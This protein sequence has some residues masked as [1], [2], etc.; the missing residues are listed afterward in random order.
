M[1]SIQYAALTEETLSSRIGAI[2][3]IAQRLGGDPSGWS[4]EEVGDGNLNLVFIVRG[5]LDTVIVKQ[6][7]PY[8]RMVGDS[9]P[10]PLYRATYEHHALVRQAERDPGSV[11]EVIH[12]D[13]NQALIAMEYLTPHTIL[14]K[15]LIEG[16]RV[17]G[18]GEFLGKFC[19]RTAFRGSEL[20]MQSADKKA[21][22]GVFSGNVA[23]PAI[24]EALVFTDPYYPAE[25]NH[26]NAVLDPL[27]TALR[28]DVALKVAAQQMLQ[29]FASNTETMV[30]GDLHSGSVM[31]TDRESKV[32]D[33]E[34]SQYGPM[35]FDVGM[36]I[37]NFLMS[38]FSQPAHRKSADLSDYQGWLMAQIM[39][40][41]SRFDEEFT[42]L[43]DSERTGMLYPAAL[44]E[45]QGHSSQP[46]LQAVLD[47]IWHDALGICGI[48]MH[49]RVLSL[50]HNAD[51]E[52]IEN[53]E[54]RGKL[55][56]RNLMMGRDLVLQRSGSDPAQLIETL[57][58]RYAE[59][60]VL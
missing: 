50:A 15:K 7:L 36:L 40:V 8:V 18:L 56:A 58:S 31:C 41:I 43:W 35:G 13:E 21:D 19:A 44:F 60:D 39:T 45:D 24:T 27:V 11:P 47:G 34:F 3:P 2:K 23:I 20:S 51:F 9:W 57:A 42:R 32:I 10:L 53:I 4:I 59:E 12:F 46:A 26:H 33:P 22:V 52:T 37:A 17:E 54:E 6:A 16:E 5:T 14:R 48:E 29:A 55:E 38:F 49:R 25:M 1:A 30:H 28:S